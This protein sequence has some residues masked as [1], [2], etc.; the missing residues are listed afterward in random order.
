[1]TA[2]Y[3]PQ[4][5]VCDSPASVALQGRCSSWESSLIQARDRPV[6]RTAIP[7]STA[8]DDN[9]GPNP[10]MLPPTYLFS[11]D[12]LTAASETREELMRTGFESD[13]L[14]LRPVDDEAGPVEGN[15]VSGNGIAMDGS[16]SSGVI[17]GPEI[18]YQA[19]FE[20]TV[21]RGACLLHVTLRG[22]LTREAA[23][24]VASRHGG[25][26]VL[27]RSEGAGNPEPQTAPGGDATSL[28]RRD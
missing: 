6:R 21:T 5:P 12:T 22:N 25:V 23:A 20:R 4:R 17:A 15:W 14:Q 9:A 19:N 18:P 26:D 10:M 11:F 27:A 7:L 16:R 1:M 13:D 2:R 3:G 24:A 8:K 28:D